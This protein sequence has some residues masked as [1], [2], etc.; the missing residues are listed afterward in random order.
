M[1]PP[2]LVLQT[3][4][5][6]LMERC[7]A[8]AFVASFPQDGGFVAKT[9]KGRKYWYFQSGANGSRSQKYVGPETPELLEQIARQKEAREDE[10]ERR[11]LVSTLV[12]SFGLP[13]PIPEMG[14]VLAAMEKT[15]VFRLRAVLIGTVAYQTYSAMLGAKL[16]APMLMTGDIDIAQ[17]SDVSVAVNDSIPPILDILK[18]VDTTFRAVPTI[19]KDSVTSYS[20]KGSLR[21]D[22]LVPN[23]G[24]DSDKPRPLPALQTDAQPLRFLDFLIREPEPAVILHGPG[25]YVNVPSPQRY[26]IHKLIVTRRRSEGSAKRDKDLHQAEA[27]LTLLC[28]KRPHELKSAWK[29]AYKRGPKWRELL[30]EGLGQLAPPTRDAVCELTDMSF[31]RAT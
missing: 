25:V 5:A 3:T 1:P 6:E 21:V 7:A 28:E 24:P 20:A 17:F 12:R 18:S 31:P 19:Y 13:R 14:E 30:K 29:E 8:A 2:S 26:A 9:V 10:R 23:T 16:S 27:L 4:Y 15:G 22:F 11:S